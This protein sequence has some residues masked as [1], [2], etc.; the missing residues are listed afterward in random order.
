MNNLTFNQL[1][2]QLLDTVTPLGV[3]YRI[4]YQSIKRPFGVGVSGTYSSARNRINVIV[5]GKSSYLAILATLAHEVRHA[6]HHHLGLF[7]EYYDPNLE[8]KEYRQLVRNGQV[9]PPTLEIGQAAEDDCNLFAVNWLA[10]KGHSLNPDK[11][12]YQVFFKPYPKYDLLTYRLRQL[13]PR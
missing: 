10:E 11:K 5:R 4:T 12:T 3:T 13:M 1:K 7:P 9:V 8:S 6:Q 2:K